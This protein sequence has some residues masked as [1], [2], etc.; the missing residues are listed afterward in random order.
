MKRCI[1]NV[2]N[3]EYDEIL[4]LNHDALTWSPGDKALLH[5]LGAILGEGLVERLQQYEECRMQK[6]DALDGIERIQEETPIPTLPD[7]GL[8]LPEAGT[9]EDLASSK[10]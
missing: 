7:Q 5:G 2:T 1:L 4:Q 3:H 8:L 9:S 10:N 6:H